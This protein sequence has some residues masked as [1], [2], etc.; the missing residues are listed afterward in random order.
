MVWGVALDLNSDVQSV[1]A[2][3]DRGRPARRRASSDAYFPAWYGSSAG[4]LASR[5]ERR[6]VGFGGVDLFS[7]GGIPDVGGMM[8][9]LGTIGNSPSSSGGGGRAAS[10]A[11]ARAVAEAAPG[12]GF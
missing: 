10:A 11:A 5:R 8:A 1:L 4:G 9:A 6:L 7:S 12:G 2:P 3:D